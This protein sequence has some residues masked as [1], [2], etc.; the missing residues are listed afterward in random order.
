MLTNYLKFAW[1][2]LSNNKGFSLINILGLSI[3]ITVA[4]M[5]GLWLK[6]E[7]TYNRNHLNYER[8]AGVWVTQTFDTRTG[9]GNAIPI[10]LEDE[11]RANFPQDFKNMSRASWSWDHTLAK[12]SDK[13]IQ[14]E[15]MFVE[16]SFPEMFSL[17]MI[18]G[19]ISGILKDVNSV[20]LCESVAHAL[21]GQ[22]NPMGQ[23]LRLD[24]DKDVLVSGVFRDFPKNS[25]FF[26]TKMF[27][28]WEMHKQEEWVKHSLDKWD[29]HSWQM[30]VE[31]NDPAQMQA[32]SDKIE[33]VE[34]AH[35]KDG[36]PSLFLHPMSRWHLYS[37]FKNGKNI[38]GRI[39]YAWLFGI[40]GLFVLL[41]ACIN[42]MNLATARSEKRAR[43]VGIRKSIG[44][45]RSQLIKQFLSESLLV[46]VLA[47]VIAL[48]LVWLFLPDFNKLADKKI[49][50]PL[51]DPVFWSAIG[52]F[53]VFTA[54]LSGSYPAF[55]LS[56]FQPIKV[57]KG[58]FRTARSASLPRKVLVVLQFTVS[59]SMII[60]TIVVFKQIEY[61]KSRPVGYARKGLIQTGITKEME[62]RYDVVRQELMGSGVVE[63]M[64]WSNS[65]ATEIYSNQIGFS[66]EGKDPNSQPMFGIVDCTH[67]FGASIGWQ[68]KEGRD[69]SKDFATDSSALIFN[70]SAVKLTGLTDIVGK[71]IRQDDEDFHVVGVV[72][73]LVM[74]SP[75][76]PIKPTIFR[77]NYEWVSTM[78]I[79]LKP[80][81]PAHDAVAGVEAVIKKVSPGAVFDYKFTD[82]EYDAKFRSE[83]RIGRLARWFAILA[84]FI[85]C[86]GLFGLSAYVAER[87]TKEIGI[88]K[89][90]G[91]TASQLWA[92]LSREFL[93]LVLISCG[94]AIPIAWHYL[95][96]WLADF[97]Y[98]IKLQWQFFFVSGVLALTI[99]L[100]TISFQSIRAALTNPVQSLRNE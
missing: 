75:Y 59:I 34:R 8:L 41:L 24:Q 66:W 3:G 47:L 7:L 15:G 27:L 81:I 28:P 18:Q 54:L 46:S 72:K 44:S 79:R 43:E 95:N 56:S 13:I 77:I 12:G 36:N 58:T 89:V 61:A 4:V 69:F 87:R 39:Q 63:E 31:V 37:E 100:L 26:A 5:I 6:D 91:A 68:I 48:V 62:D 21:F 38:G 42:F 33:G 49:V 93:L 35:N 45:G 92:M 64:S 14:E 50:Y 20:V 74:E 11:L 29:N 97:D 40:I 86:L 84:I 16:P 73:D 94:L 25:E 22:E 65:P 30:F 2:N 9:S 90:L 80:G 52:A 32:V 10:P 70:E 83:E 85:S 67:D 82:E 76:K 51:G 23:T 78:N 19:D 1:R 99:T 55:Y 88:R 60:G 71:T 96:N 57:L 17:Q 53:T 98:R